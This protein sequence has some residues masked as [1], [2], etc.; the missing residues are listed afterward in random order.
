MIE[1]F[2]ERLEGVLETVPDYYQES[3]VYKNIISVYLKASQESDDA[4]RD[5]ILQ[6]YVQTATWG[7]DYWEHDYAITPNP[8]DSIELR[9]SRILSKMTG[10]GTFTKAEAL[11]LANVYSEPQDAIFRSI[12]N[13]YAFKTRHNIDH[14]VDYEG[15]IEA[16]EEMKPAHLEHLVGFLIRLPM[17][18]AMTSGSKLRLGYSESYNFNYHTPMKIKVGATIVVPGKYNA[19]P[20]DSLALD[21]S[22]RMDGYALLD[23]KAPGGKLHYIHNSDQLTIRKYQDGQLVSTDTI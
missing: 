19:D 11:R 15:M 2:E 7:L 16:F 9:R 20:P 3:S 17:D 5:L 13:E 4:R 21:G 18:V 10:L 23:A 12:K 6:L 1:H 14:I 8:G 22:F